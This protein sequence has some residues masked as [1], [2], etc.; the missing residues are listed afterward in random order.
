M[1]AVSILEMLEGLIIMW[2]PAIA[3]IIGIFITVITTIAKIRAVVD[4]LKND[5]TVKNVEEKFERLDCKMDEILKENVCLKK[6]NRQLKEALTRVRDNEE[7][8]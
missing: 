1:T 2:G 5:N 4:N 3:A 6:Q 8:Q 7:I